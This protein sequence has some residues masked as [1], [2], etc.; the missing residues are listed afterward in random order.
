MTACFSAAPICTQGV[1]GQLKFT[2]WNSKQ[3]P[4]EQMGC[5]ITP[6]FKEV[7]C[8]VVK[9]LNS[10][11]FAPLSGKLC[12]RGSDEGFGF[13]FRPWS[14]DNLCILVRNQNIKHLKS[15]RC[16]THIPQD[17]RRTMWL[18]EHRRV[19]PSQESHC[20][21]T[22]QY[23][24]SHSR[25]PDE[26]PVITTAAASSYTSQ[27]QLC[28]L[29]CNPGPAAPVRSVWWATVQSTSADRQMDEEASS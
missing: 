24:W 6:P 2:C 14:V 20:G 11:T 28:S 7:S 18:W 12:L 25:P 8:V 27:L 13:R 21:E 17:C 3:I 10:K 22:F 5:C 26:S 1:L 9:V 23:S 15:R 4:G 16:C 19:R 29:L